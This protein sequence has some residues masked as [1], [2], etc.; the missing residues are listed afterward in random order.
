M[1]S[2]PAYVNSKTSMSQSNHLNPIK[3]MLSSKVLP[4]L[5]CDVPYNVG[6][7]FVLFVL[8][9]SVQL[10]KLLI[11]R[12]KPW[13]RLSTS[14]LQ[15]IYSDLLISACAPSITIHDSFHTVNHY[16]WTALLVFRVS[17]SLYYTIKFVELSWCLVS[18]PINVSANRVSDRSKFCLT[19]RL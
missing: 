15:N 12:V 3:T 1:W 16:C 8:Y 14:S 5:F 11:F 10:E 6:L 4:F 9:F 2:K 18:N 7:V 17:L 19:T 13:T